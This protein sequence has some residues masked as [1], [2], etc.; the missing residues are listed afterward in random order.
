MRFWKKTDNM[1][2][3]FDISLKNKS[4][5]QWFFKDIDSVY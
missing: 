1:T 5:F 2:L 4:L 3:H